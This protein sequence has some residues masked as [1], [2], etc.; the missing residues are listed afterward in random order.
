[1]G[2][3]QGNRV[4]D[5]LQAGHVESL[6]EVFPRSFRRVLV[7]V[8]FQMESAMWCSDSLESSSILLCSFR[9]SCTRGHV[10]LFPNPLLP[11]AVRT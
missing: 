2:I 5:V 8:V 11:L 1:M 10:F 6:G 9:V 7:L 3:G 4:S